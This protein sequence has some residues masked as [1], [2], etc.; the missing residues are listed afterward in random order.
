MKRPVRCMS[1]DFD[2]PTARVSRWVWR[3]AG[4]VVSVRGSRGVY[5][6]SSSFTDSL[7]T[8]TWNEG[9]VALQ[10]EFNGGTDHLPSA[11]EMV[12]SAD[13]LRRIDRSTFEALPLNPSFMTADDAELLRFVR[14]AIPETRAYDLTLHH[15]NLDASGRDLNPDGLA[16]NGVTRGGAAGRYVDLYAPAGTVT[17]VLWLGASSTPPACAQHVDI[18]NFEPKVPVAT[19]D[20]SCTS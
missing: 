6:A 15:Q 4:T 14:I 13:A 17:L 11:A 1:I 12:S 20:L 3:S 2:L 8:L 7:A 10:L 9:G 18:T 19:L 16:P 5:G